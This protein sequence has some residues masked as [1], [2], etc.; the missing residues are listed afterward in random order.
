MMCLVACGMGAL[1]LVGCSSD[2]SE[3]GN[4]KREDRGDRPAVADPPEVPDIDACFNKSQAPR[5]NVMAVCW[6]AYKDSEG[7]GQLT[8]VPT[9]SVAYTEPLLD[10]PNF[11]NSELSSFNL[12]FDEADRLTGIE[13]E[14]APD[15]Y[16]KEI[17]ARWDEADH[18]PATAKIVR[19]QGEGIGILFSK[20]WADLSA[21][22]TVG[23]KRAW[24]RLKLDDDDRLT[25]MVFLGAYGAA[26]MPEPMTEALATQKQVAC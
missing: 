11:E 25:G 19:C 17:A 22:I 21:D 2:D 8:L 7:Y 10:D 1:L 15:V 9:P 23:G 13:V 3:V 6:E 24:L 5:P 12:D 26:R 18:L 20:E 4:A 16:P 14:G